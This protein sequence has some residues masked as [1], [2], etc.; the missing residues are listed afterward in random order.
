MDISLVGKYKTH[1]VYLIYEGADYYVAFGTVDDRYWYKA[2]QRCLEKPDYVMETK[3]GLSIN[4]SDPELIT[5]LR[6][7]GRIIAVLT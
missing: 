6:D 7:I 2:L 3:N 1:D 5:L 4:F